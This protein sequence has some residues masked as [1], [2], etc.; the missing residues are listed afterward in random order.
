MKNLIAA[1]INKIEMVWWNIV[2]GFIAGF[3]VIGV[4][5][6]VRRYTARQFKKFF[7]VNNKNEF[8]LIYCLYNAPLPPLDKPD[9][10]PVFEKPPHRDGGVSASSG[11]N[12]NQVTSC[13]S[14]KGVGYLANAFSKNIKTSP[15]ILADTDKTITTRMDLSFIS[16][17][18]KTNYKTC[19]LLSNPSNVFVDFDGSRIITKNYGR[20]VIKLGTERGYDYGF[21]IKIHPRNN[22][23]RTWICCAGFG[24]PGTSGAAYYL[25]YKWKKIRKWAGDKQFACVIKT[26]NASDDS[27]EPIEGFIKKT[28]LLSRAIQMFRCRKESFKITEIE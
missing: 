14:A 23:E 17:G 8:H 9:W 28:N 3:A 4:Q 13:A 6:F 15:L 21:I 12:L 20:T 2:G 7:G 25:A 27:T 26:E 19:D 1:G 5:F 22:T 10:K 18:G 11:V 16:I 24:I